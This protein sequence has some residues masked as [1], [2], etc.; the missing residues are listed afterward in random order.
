[1]LVK[2]LVDDSSAG[3]NVVDAYALRADIIKWCI[4]AYFAA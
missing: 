2:R 1:V 4:D 3:A